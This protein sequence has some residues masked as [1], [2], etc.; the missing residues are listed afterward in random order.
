[1]SICCLMK[2][3]TCTLPLSFIAQFFESNFYKTH[4][5][6]SFLINT[7]RAALFDQ[8]EWKSW[9]VWPE[10]TWTPTIRER[11]PPSTL[12]MLSPKPPIQS[13]LETKHALHC[14]L[15]ETWKLLGLF[16]GVIAPLSICHTHQHLAARLGSLKS[17]FTWLKINKLKAKLG[18]SQL[19]PIWYLKW[20]V[21]LERKKL[22][23]NLR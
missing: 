4:N 13:C 11:R 16:M 22:P 1:M 19:F 5:S 10:V 8:E 17:Y 3:F 20:K 18:A 15:L 12:L 9:V 14:I 2:L 21:K 6:W 7:R 23:S